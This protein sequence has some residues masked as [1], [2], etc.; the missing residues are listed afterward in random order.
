MELEKWFYS[1]HR[2]SI[3]F[4]HLL[5]SI[6]DMAGVAEGGREYTQNALCFSC[7]VLVQ[8]LSACP[9]FRRHISAVLGEGVRRGVVGVHNSPY[10]VCRSWLLALLI[11]SYMKEDFC[12]KLYQIELMKFHGASVLL[13]WMPLQEWPRYDPRSVTLSLPHSILLSYC[14]LY[15]LG[16]E[17]TYSSGPVPFFAF[18][19]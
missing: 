10:S 8:Q 4:C 9:P 1:Q 5:P 15:V 3:R 13:P 19:Q 2:P 18:K 16:W 12:Q 14:S 17:F 6:G 7:S 11:A